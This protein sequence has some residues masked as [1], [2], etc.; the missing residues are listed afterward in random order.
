MA[1]SKP[2]CLPH[3]GARVGVQFLSPSKSGRTPLQLLGISDQELQEQMAKGHPYAFNMGQGTIIP[4]KD[5]KEATAALMER[6]ML[7]VL[8]GHQT[9]AVF[10]P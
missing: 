10:V 5:Y 8:T 2:C 9:K 1:L 3:D 4:F 6:N 7:E